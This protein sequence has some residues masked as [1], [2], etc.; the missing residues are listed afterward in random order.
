MGPSGLPQ[1]LRTRRQRRTA[2]SV[3]G[4]IWMKQAPAIIISDQRQLSSAS[5]ERGEEVRH[6]GQ[7]NPKLMRGLFQDLMKKEEIQSIQVVIGGLF[8]VAAVVADLAHHLT[9]DDGATDIFPALCTRK[10][11][12]Q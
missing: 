4:A 1:H 3:I 10:F 11:R 5:H 12:K 2:E 9:R 6:S 8:K 7:P